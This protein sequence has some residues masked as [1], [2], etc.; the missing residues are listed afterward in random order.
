[1]KCTFLAL[2]KN[3]IKKDVPGGYFLPYIMHVPLSAPFVTFRPWTP[4]LPAHDTQDIKHTVFPAQDGSDPSKNGT[5]WPFFASLSLAG[6]VDVPKH[7]VFAVQ[8]R[9]PAKIVWE[10]WTFFAL[11]CVKWAKRVVVVTAM[12]VPMYYFQHF[13]RG[14]SPLPQ[15]PLR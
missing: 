3:T 4:P 7:M 8:N 6:S 11:V 14:P 10:W 2:F 9:S 15:L 13:A 12:I 5:T 1:M